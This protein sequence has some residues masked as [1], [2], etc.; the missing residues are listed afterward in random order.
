M[1]IFSF[2]TF[3][4]STVLSD[5]L[6]DRYLLYSQ[7]ILLLFVVNLIKNLEIKLE[8][9]P[10]LVTYVTFTILYSMD[11]YYDIGIKWKMSDQLS[12]NNKLNKEKIFVQDNYLK[13]NFILNNQDYSGVGPLKPSD[14]EYI[15]FVVNDIEERPSY[16]REILEFSSRVLNKTTIFGDTGIEGYGF[17]PSQVIDC[18]ECKILEK[19]Y[20]FSPIYEII[21]VSK[22]V[23]SY[24]LDKK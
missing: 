5:V 15:C 2:I 24:C 9:L 11:F 18:K 4:I 14:P 19:E 8:I 12:I 3:S 1:L 13:F 22:F 6:Y 17:T 23:K 20:Y 16:I 7:I 21:G 10:I